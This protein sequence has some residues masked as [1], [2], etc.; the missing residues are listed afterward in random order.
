MSCVPS[1]NLSEQS[2]DDL[3]DPLT[4]LQQSSYRSIITNL[5]IN[6]HQPINSPKLQ[7]HLSQF[8]TQFQILRFQ[9]LNFHS[10]IPFI[11]LLH[12]LHSI[13]LLSPHSNT[14]IILMTNSLFNQF[15]FHFIDKC[16]YTL[17]P[18]FNDLSI[19]VILSYTVF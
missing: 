3:F 6:S 13:S 11:T 17:L 12:I 15:S 9:S 8:R 16:L 5:L 10:I 18:H 7:F 2:L 4:K 1:Y 19:N 14:L